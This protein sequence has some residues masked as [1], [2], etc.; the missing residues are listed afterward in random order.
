MQVPSCI[1]SE[2]SVPYPERR[3]SRILPPTN[4]PL[5]KV[6]GASGGIGTEYT[7]GSHT[8]G[9]VD[10]AEVFGFRDDGVYK[11]EVGDSVVRKI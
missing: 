10:R 5:G 11:G 7:S 9:D 6:E 3:D 4:L 8:Y 1:L 2:I